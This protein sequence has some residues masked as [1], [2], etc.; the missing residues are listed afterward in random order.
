MLAFASSVALL[1]AVD[2]Q[3]PPKKFAC[4]GDQCVVSARGLP[5]AECQ[6]ACEPAPSANY[7]C[8]NGQCAVASRGLPLAE[9]QQVCGA[10]P[11]AGKT[12]VDLAVATPELSTLVAALKAGDLVDTLSGKGPF[13]VFAPTNKAFAALNSSGALA[14][15]LT[16]ENKG[17]LVEL[18]GYH[19]IP[20]VGCDYPVNTP[21][22]DKDLN[23][24]PGCGQ[25][26]RTTV[27]GQNITVQVCSHSCGRGGRNNCKQVC[28][29]TGNRKPVIISVTGVKASNGFVHI[30]DTVLQQPES[31]TIVGTVSRRPDLSTLATALKAGGLIDALSNAIL[32]GGIIQRGGIQKFTVFAPSDKAFAALPAGTIQNLLKP[33]NRVALIDLLTYHVVR[34]DVQAN[35]ISDGGSIMTARGSKVTARI[36]SAVFRLGL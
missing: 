3:A 28:V 7:S 24:K 19:V 16:P 26:Q 10:G 6:S 1:A 32:P 31:K 8:V 11:P 33:A 20:G 25:G 9:C 30:I 5:L 12:I 14:N 17:L 23:F 34:G 2:A 36:R 22:G 18:L 21:Q 27:E 15:L 4:I 13:T 35:Q 29:R